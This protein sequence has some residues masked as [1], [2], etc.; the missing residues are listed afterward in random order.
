M[1]PGEKIKHL[2]LQQQFTQQELA[3]AIAKKYPKSTIVRAD[4]VNWEIG[5]NYPSWENAKILVQYLGITLDQL[6]F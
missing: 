4:I 3:D 6:F 1:T 5:R 2:R